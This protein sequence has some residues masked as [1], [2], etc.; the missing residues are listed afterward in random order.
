VTDYL[1]TSSAV[2]RDEAGSAVLSFSISTD[3]G[4]VLYVFVNGQF[5]STSIDNENTVSTMLSR[6]KEENVTGELSK[7]V[8]PMKFVVDLVQGENRVDILFASMGLKNYG[9]VSLDNHD[10]K[11]FAFII[12]MMIAGVSLNS[13]WKKSE[14]VWYQTF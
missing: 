2:E 1:W 13:T 11:Q 10:I 12:L 14:L 6:L 3:G 4:P 8:E 7:T 9:P 5:V